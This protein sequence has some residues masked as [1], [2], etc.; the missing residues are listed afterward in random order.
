LMTTRR[1]KQAVEVVLSDLWSALCAHQGVVAAAVSSGVH[2]GA[3]PEV[4]KASGAVRRASGRL[5]PLIA[6]DDEAA[7]AETLAVIRRLGAPGVACLIA[8]MKLTKDAHV[9]IA[10]IGALAEIAGEHVIAVTFAIH[11]AVARHDDEAHRRA[12]LAAM[13]ALRRAMVTQRPMFEGM[14]AT[15]RD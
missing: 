7:R 14:T 8:T 4:K 11:D 12:Y 6:N 10:A 3:M 13:P 5:A 2:P 15:E 9:R 1:K